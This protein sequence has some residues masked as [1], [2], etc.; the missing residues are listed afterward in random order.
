MFNLIR[1]ILPVLGNVV[2]F[3]GHKEIHIF[4]HLPHITPSFNNNNNKFIFSFLGE[5]RSITRQQ[6]EMNINFQNEDL[7]LGSSKQ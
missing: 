2:H 1:H 5:S 3:L 4:R 6:R 7:R